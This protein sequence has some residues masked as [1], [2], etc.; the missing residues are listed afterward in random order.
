MVP[1]GF[2]VV[3][4]DIESDV[5]RGSALAV[6]LSR[7]A[8]AFSRVTTAM[9]AAGEQSGQLAEALRNVVEHLEREA[10]FRS[11]VLSV[12]IYPTILAVAGASTLTVLLVFV[13]PRF[14]ELIQSGG[15][16]IPGLVGTVL[17][18]RA[19]LAAH[20]A[21]LVIFILA[22]LSSIA[23]ALQAPS[24]RRL[25]SEALYRIP[26]LSGLRR[27]IIGARFT[28]S[29][30]ML[31][32]GGTPITVALG[33]TGAG[34]QDPVAREAIERILEEVR[35]GAALR[36]AVKTMWFLPPVASQLISVG[37][38]SGDLPSHLLMSADILERD[39]ERR[40]DRLMVMAEPTMILIFGGLI[41]LVALALLQA[42]YGMQGGVWR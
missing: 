6:A 1:S 7:H 4:A 28:R 11:R 41:G 35:G 40:M 25:L 36:N 5:S 31:L 38:R 2:A 20:V 42:V 26:L 3:A 12:S 19:F 39:V 37:E 33:G 27:S 15:G 16:E 9:V 22:T 21:A 29:L 8:V 23:V 14:A 24:G 13:L 32:A 34:M 10:A 17:S 18:A 30:G